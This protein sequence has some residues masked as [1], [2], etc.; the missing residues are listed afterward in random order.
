MADRLVEQRIENLKE[1][2]KL[3]INPYPYKFEKQDYAAE[4]QKTFAKL[5][6]EEKVKTI[7]RTAGRLMTIRD[8]GKA[9]F[10]NLHDE[11]GKVQLFI[12][13]DFVGDKQYALFKRF[14]LGDIIGIEG[15]VFKTKTGEVTIEVKKIELL[16]K[17][18]RPLPEKWHGIS[19]PEIIY[20]QRYVDL[21]IS[22]EK[23]DVFVMRSKILNAVREFLME[24]GFTEFETPVLQPIYGG[25]NA[26]PFK[27]KHNAL[28][29]ELFLRISPELYLKRLI[30]GG[31]EK[32][33]EICKN[34]RNEGMDHTHNPEFTMLEAYQAYADYNDMMDLFE[35]IYE[36][37]AKKVLGTTKI[38]YQ[39]KIIDVK[40]P[41]KR[42]PMLDAIKQHTNIGD[43]RKLTDQEL[44]E[45]MRNYNVEYEGDWN[46]GLAIMRIF[47]E[48][49][50]G[51]IEQP[52]FI[53]DHPKETTPLCKL[54]RKHP[55][56]VER[57]E[58]FINGWEAGNAYSE[59]NDPILQ[60][61]LLQ[62]QA[63]QLRAGVEEAHPMDEDF[64][65]AIEFGM[66]PTGG[67]G[68]GI[69]RMTMLFTNQASIRDVILFPTLRKKE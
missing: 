41:W 33:F 17:S 9:A 50:E 40:K 65:R 45:I 3:G 32:V 43:V 14:D 53:T 35:S 46:R 68:L 64:L 27:T 34:F 18:L 24:K 56:L 29:M 30:V 54:H 19:D 1:L 26:K 31:Y 47:E 13:K 60:R 25:A 28:D 52:T 36:Y 62:K 58:P 20:R 16:C 61:V 12:R 6:N 23:R 57:F 42:I 37:A 5:K 39:N 49:V 8:M 15:P 21:M 44:K 51:K 4:I 67:I 2:V 48:L 10:A 11:S 7:V 59:L 69:D 55:D 22:K 38:K 63:E 66:P